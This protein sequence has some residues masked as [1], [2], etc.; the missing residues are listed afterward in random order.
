MKKKVLCSEKNVIEVGKWSYMTQF[1]FL[2][3]IEESEILSTF[4]NI[5]NIDN[6]KHHYTFCTPIIY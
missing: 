4:F 1:L 6:H 5:S 3:K 2:E